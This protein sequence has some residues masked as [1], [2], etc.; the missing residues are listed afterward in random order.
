MIAGTVQNST[1][2]I[3][4]NIFIVVMDAMFVAN[5]ARP[6]NKQSKHG[7]NDTG[8]KMSD[9]PEFIQVIIVMPVMMV[10]IGLMF[11][12]MSL[13]EALAERIKQNE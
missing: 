2:I 1:T 5:D 12:T 13:C 4:K 9:L 11:G 3:V 7:T 6:N 10:S 8:L